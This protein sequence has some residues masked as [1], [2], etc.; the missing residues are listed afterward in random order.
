V[1]AGDFCVINADL[2]LSLVLSPAAKII[3][4]RYNFYQLSAWNPND[5]FASIKIV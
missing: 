4:T 1:C 3:S 5:S 2:A